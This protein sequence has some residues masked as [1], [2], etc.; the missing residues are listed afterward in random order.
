MQVRDNGNT[1]VSTLVLTPHP[2]DQGK[3]LECRA[4]NP[5]IQ[6]SALQDSWKLVVHREGLNQL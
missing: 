4:D 2:R 3:T 1:T 5:S 6:G